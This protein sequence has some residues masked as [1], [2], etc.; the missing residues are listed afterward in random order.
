[1][2]GGALERASFEAIVVGASRGGVE[3]L[4]RMVAK[5]PAEFPLPVLVVEHRRES[6]DSALAAHLATRCALPVKEA[7]DKEPVAPGTVFLAPGGYHLLVERDRTL[8]LSVDEPMHF[9][10]PSIDVLFETA[11]EAFGGQLLG[12]ILT[13]SG[14][15]GAEGLAQIVRAGGAA[16]VQDPHT[17][18]APEMPLAA[19][20]L[21]QPDA[22]L[23]VDE[24]GALLAEVGSAIGRRARS[25]PREARHE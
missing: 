24:I 3:A 2:S 15:D 1:V 8:S 25:K 19:L 4:G 13:G 18:Q 14:R 7:E 6:S 5:L 20:A 10:R 17:A 12:V 23:G 11:A 9:C 16:V 22:V 21:T